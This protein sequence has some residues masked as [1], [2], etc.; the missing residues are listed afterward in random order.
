M[1]KFS[2]SYQGET[3][4]ELSNE[5]IQEYTYDLNLV[6]QEAKNQLLSLDESIFGDELL[7]IDEVQIIL[8]NLSQSE[9]AFIP[10]KGYVMAAQ[11]ALSFLNNFIP[12]LNCDPGMITGEMSENELS[13]AI[14]SFGE[15]FNQEYNQN[16]GLNQEFNLEL[17]AALQKAVSDTLAFTGAGFEKGLEAAVTANDIE[18]PKKWKATLLAT[19]KN[20]VSMVAYTQGDY[21]IYKNLYSP[22]IYNRDGNRVGFKSGGIYHFHEPSN[23]WPVENYVVEGPIVNPFEGHKR[24]ARLSTFRSPE[25]GDVEQ[26]L[27]SDAGSTSASNSQPMPKPITPSPRETKVIAEKVAAPIQKPS[28]AVSADTNSQAT[29]PDEEETEEASN[30]N[31]ESPEVR[32]FNKEITDLLQDPMLEQGYKGH[33]LLFY[34]GQISV[35]SVNPESLYIRYQPLSN[36]ASI[37]NYGI[38]ALDNTI[39]VSKRL[40]VYL[41]KQE[42]QNPVIKFLLKYKAINLL[43]HPPRNYELGKSIYGIQ[44]QVSD[45]QPLHQVTEA[46][47]R[48]DRYTGQGNSVVSKPGEPVM[49]VGAGP[50]V[51]LS[52]Y[53]PKTKIGSIS[54]IDPSYPLE[55]KKIEGLISQ[56]G[57]KNPED[58]RV[59]MFG[60]WT[61]FSERIIYHLREFFNK[62]KV[63]IQKEDILGGGSRSVILDTET[64]EHKYIDKSHFRKYHFNTLIKHGG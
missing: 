33:K 16:L 23:G 43:S 28:L 40:D 44:E 51:I 19:D 15:W 34:N 9:G 62:Q 21:V 13:T 48:V 53:N 42:L 4:A 20:G 11:V 58:L 46:E 39:H 18:N 22:V 30:T 52:M 17:A 6:D 2:D 63:K 56:L 1:E 54:H 24:I 7:N 12:N 50:C 27:H 47:F 37:R 60:G 29:R 61:G 25:L 38:L 55:D 45:Q 59:S 31:D 10:H 36:Q 41:T 3:N 49:T 35:C 5:N 32:Q 26:E 57:I 14:D 64:G 8:T